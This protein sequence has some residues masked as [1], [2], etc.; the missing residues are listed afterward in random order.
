MN[1][2]AV[3]YIRVSTEEQSSEGHSLENQRRMVEAYC[4]GRGLDL[5]EVFIDAGVSAS[6]ELAQR[7][8]G[9][10]LCRMLT[11]GR[12]GDRPWHV[13]SPKLDRMFRSSQNCL[14]QI[15]DWERRGIAIHLLDLALDTST[16]TGRM[17]LTMLAAVAQ[18]ERDLTRERTRSTSDHLRRAG[19][20][21]SR[22]IPYGFAY[23]QEKRRLVPVPEEQAVVRQIEDLRQQEQSYLAIARQLQQQEVPTKRG[24]QWSASRVHKIHRAMSRNL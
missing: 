2:K 21:Y 20:R 19:L 17:V 22:H 9:A 14:N 1:N 12:R 8:A 11:A 18:M 15:A 23:D 5:V 4:L 10:S 6:R 13:I 16:P 7:P 3:A 24:G